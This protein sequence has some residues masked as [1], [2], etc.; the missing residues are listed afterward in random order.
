MPGPDPDTEME[1]G[2]PGVEGGA[3]FMLLLLSR[4]ED[5]LRAEEGGRKGNPPS[6]LETDAEAEEDD[7]NEGGKGVKIR[8]EGSSW[9]GPSCEKASW[10][11]SRDWFRGRRAGEDN[12]ARGRWIEVA[13]EVAEEWW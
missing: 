1:L 7:D 8:V 13:E 11:D 4:W 10:I 3:P 9:G 2:V 5:T 6:G 12:W